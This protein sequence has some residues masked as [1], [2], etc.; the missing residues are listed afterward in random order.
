MTNAIKFAIT[1]MAPNVQMQARCSRVAVTP[2]S[3]VRN[4]RIEILLS[5]DD[6]IENEGAIMVY[7]IA[8]CLW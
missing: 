3:R 2:I 1:K 4:I 5:V 6:T 8:I 7:F